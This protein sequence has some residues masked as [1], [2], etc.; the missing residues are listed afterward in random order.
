MSHVA[1]DPRVGSL[2]TKGPEVV[3]HGATKTSGGTDERSLAHSKLRKRAYRRARRRAEE[4]GGT[5]YR[6]RWRTAQELGTVF[7]AVES[8]APARIGPPAVR[9][10]EAKP[11]LQVRSYNA[12]GLG[13]ESYDYMYNWLVHRCREDVVILQELHWGCGRGDGNWSIPGWNFY[14]TADPQQRFSGVG[15]AVSERVAGA[16]NISCCTWVPGRLL[17]VRCY[18]HR[19]NLDIIAG[20]QWVRPTH[21]AAPVAE[22]R[23]YFWAQLGRLLQSIPQRHMVVLGADLNTRRHPIPGLVGRGVLQQNQSRDAELEALIQENDQ[24]SRSYKHLQ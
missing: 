16:C 11:R 8:A 1:A 12:G 21:A 13:M 20:Y 24:R 4:R 22:K 3:P 17:Q 23:S 6:G 5:M 18:N 15:I 9:T 19:V 2:A 14:M 10:W 7:R